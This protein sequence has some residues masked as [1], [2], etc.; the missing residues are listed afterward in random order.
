[1]KIGILGSGIVG[2]T[3]ASGFIGNGYNAMIGTRNQN[4]LKDWSAENPKCLVKSFSEVAEFGEVLVLAVKGSVAVEALG[5]IGKA[6]LSGKIIIDATN[7]IASSPPEGG[8]LKYFTTLENSLM[9]KLQ[10]EF[11][12]TFF[13]K[14]FNSVGAGCM[15][16]PDFKAGRPTMFICG[17]NTSAKKKVESILDKFGWDSAD[18]GEAIAAR[19]IE[20]LAILWC[21]P[22]FL[23]GERKHAFKLLK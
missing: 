14:A 15:V 5:L 12:E 4:K 10:H 1:M 6:R 7:P 9:E 22:S 21:I 11:P 16:N 8:L 20:P 19:A 18:M 13:V 23:K 3:L 2:K 17:N